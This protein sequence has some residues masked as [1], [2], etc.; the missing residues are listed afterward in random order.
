MRRL[1]ASQYTNALDAAMRRS[2]LE[3]FPEPARDAILR[4]C[5]RVDFPAKTYFR[6]PEQPRRLGL[7]VRG[8]ARSTY[9]TRDG[10]E[11]TINWGHPGDWLGDFGSFGGD[12]DV[13]LQAVKP[14]VWA[15][16]DVPRF[17]ALLSTDAAAARCVMAILED[18]MRRAI[19]EEALL[20]YGD[21]RTRTRRRLLESACRAPGVALVAR[22]T[23]E[24]LATSVGA[25]RQS[26]ARALGEL[27]RAGAIR[28]T[29][30]GIEILNARALLTGARR[31]A[32]VA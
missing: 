10:H 11:L 5:V 20:A 9:L 14:L 24:Q 19:E 29:S 12:S 16:L 1:D 6:S 2:V 26:V 27:R 28:T 3:A 23:Q 8:L 30:A 13:Y 15:D 4:L 21:V 31:K 17:L 7:V 32:A 22:I 25:T 18:T